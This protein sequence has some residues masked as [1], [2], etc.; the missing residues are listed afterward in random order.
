MK[1]FVNK[2]TLEI[3]NDARWGQIVVD[4]FFKSDK[5]LNE[6]K[7]EL[8]KIWIPKEIEEVEVRAE[9]SHFN[10]M[11]HIGG[12]CTAPI[13]PMTGCPKFVHSTHDA[14]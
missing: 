6:V 10:C 14:K 1:V 11:Y 13:S 12:G 7:E 8:E 9:C 5:R 4:E 2:E 3:V